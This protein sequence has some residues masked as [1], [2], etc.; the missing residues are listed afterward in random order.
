MDYFSFNKKMA[1]YEDGKLSFEDTVNLFQKL[2][3][4]GEIIYMKNSY[5]IQA[6]NLINHGHIIKK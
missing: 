2:V 6:N 5:Y 3:D 1:Q 4:S